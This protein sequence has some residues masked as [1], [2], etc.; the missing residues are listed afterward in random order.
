VYKRLELEG[1]PVDPAQPLPDLVAPC[2]VQIHF[3]DGE[4][5]PAVPCLTPITHTYTRAGDY[6]VVYC[7]YTPDQKKLL[8]C[9]PVHIVEVR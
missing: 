6:A 7:T 1:M 5:S 4:R 8:G 2:V 9:S 3:G